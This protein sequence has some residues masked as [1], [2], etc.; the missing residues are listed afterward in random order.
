MGVECYEDILEEMERDEVKMIG[1][2]VEGVVQELFPGATV[3]VMGSYRRQKATCGDIDVHITHKSFVKKIPDQGLS[4]IADLLWQ[5]GHLSY[6]L[7]F[8]TGMATGSKVS[9][10]MKTSRFITKDTWKSSKPVGYMTSKGSHGASYMGVF[11]SPKIEGKQRRIDIK[12]YPW[13]ERV[14][15]S[16]YFTGN[17]YF[18][19]SMRLWA[20]RKFR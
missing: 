2:L 18:N 12:F 13:R 19:R 17:G 14:F 15:A 4:M 5:R 6:H 16:L 11:R 8:L 10:Y 7:T 1:E 3:Q 9:D 20:S